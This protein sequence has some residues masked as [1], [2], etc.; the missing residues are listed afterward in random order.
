VLPPLS[1]RCSVCGSLPSVLANVYGS[2]VVGRFVTAAVCSRSRSMAGGSCSLHIERLGFAFVFL[3][4]CLFA[5]FSGLVWWFAGQL[6]CSVVG[7]LG[8]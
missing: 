3:A 8:V 6:L 4:G 1:A 2:P 7:V 5:G